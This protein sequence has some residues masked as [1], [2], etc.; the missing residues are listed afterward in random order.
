MDLDYGPSEGCNLVDL[1]RNIGLILTLEQLENKQ[2]VASGR[3]QPWQLQQ[4]AHV[5]SF[6]WSDKISGHPPSRESPEPATVNNPSIN[7]EHADKCDKMR[8]KRMSLIN[9]HYDKNERVVPVKPY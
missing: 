5:K 7:P 1:Y 8:A 3:T 9:P 2:S 4:A 6:Y